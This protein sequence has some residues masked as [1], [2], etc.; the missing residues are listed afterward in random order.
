MPAHCHKMVAEIA[1]EAAGQLYERLMGED[2]YY[3]EW[4]RQ[5][6]DCTA[7]ELERRFIA[8]NWGKCIDFARAT[9]ATMLNGPLPDSL[10]D[11]IVD[12]LS[13]DASL[14]RGRVTG[15]QQLMH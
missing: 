8:K 7:K 9:L 15:Y 3:K 13:K 5:N 1:K 2:I 14:R 11:E 6:P 4:R 12:A 10:K